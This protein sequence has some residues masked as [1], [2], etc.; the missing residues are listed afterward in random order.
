[1][2]W[3]TPAAVRARTGA[4]VPPAT[5]KRTSTASATG[6]PCWSVTVATK[7]VT[8]SATASSVAPRV[9]ATA[10][11]RPGRNVTAAVPLA[12][13]AVAVTTPRAATLLSQRPLATPA[14]VWAV[15]GVTEPRSVA[16][17]TGVPSVTEF[18][19]ASSTVT[20]NPTPSSTA[21][22]AR[23]GRTCN[24]GRRPGL[25]GHGAGH[26]HGARHGPQERQAWLPARREGGGGHAAHRAG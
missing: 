18:P 26:G 1:M 10:A 22:F 15:P 8:P 12:P 16:K 7:D 19:N 9:R 4:A 20:A 13:P 24:G 14:T 23:P 5:S 11:G 2:D 3:A 21:G 6:F 25:D 17:T